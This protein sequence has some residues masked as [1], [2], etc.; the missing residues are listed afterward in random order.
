MITNIFEKR[1]VNHTPHSIST[2]LK[3]PTILSDTF[4][5]TYIRIKNRWGFTARISALLEMIQFSYSIEEW[6]LVDRAQVNNGELVAGWMDSLINYR[7]DKPVDFGEI[8]ETIKGTL[9]FSNREL[10]LIETGSVDERIWS[11]F[12]Y[13]LYPNLPIEY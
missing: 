2:V 13:L 7:D 1:E 12:T 3:D 10:T 8:W 11:I 4:K 5:G 9:D 6:D